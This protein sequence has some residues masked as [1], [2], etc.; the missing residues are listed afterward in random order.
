LRI[1][2]ASL[3]SALLLAAA[4]AA[5]E[6]EPALSAEWGSPLR[7]SANLGVRVGGAAPGEGQGRGVLLQVQPGLGGIAVNLGYTPFSLS[8]W[9]TQAVGVAARARFLRSWGSLSRVEPD[10]SFGGL[11]L[12]AAWI[13]K[14]S[15]GVLRRFG[16]GPGRATV[17]TWSVGVGL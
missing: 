6:V 9:G 10:Q 16:D 5:A 3:A 1:T 8:A 7:F 12:E 2:L 14:V 15:V 17:V 13:V 4:P 11:E